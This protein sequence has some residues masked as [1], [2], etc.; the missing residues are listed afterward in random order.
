MIVF[1]QSLFSLYS[2]AS[3][4]L[5]QQIASILITPHSSIFLH[6]ADV[7]LQSGG[8]D[9]GLFA[10]AYATALAFGKHP[11]YSHHCQ[12]HGKIT[13]I[14]K[15]PD[16]WSFLAHAQTMDTRLSFSPPHLIRAWGRG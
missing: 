5:Q 16:F 1:I 12:L 8:S 14:Y 9:C 13:E 6:F 15:A 3:D 7:Q 11:Q 2:S 4:E 10:I